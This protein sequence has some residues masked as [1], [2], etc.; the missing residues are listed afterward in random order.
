[1]A[2]AKALDSTRSNSERRV[3]KP[4]LPTRLLQIG[5]QE[6]LAHPTEN[7][8]EFGVTKIRSQVLH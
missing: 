6:K 4:Y 7:G 1:M 8:Q 5:G 2:A 3:G